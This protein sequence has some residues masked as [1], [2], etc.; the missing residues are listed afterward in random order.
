MLPIEYGAWLLLPYV[1]IR[2]VG[3]ANMEIGNTALISVR[4]L[5]KSF[6]ATKVLRGVN[7]TVRPGESHALLGGNGA[8]KSTMI[9]IITGGVRKDEGDVILASL[10]A[11]VPEFEQDPTQPRI[12]RTEP[13]VGYRMAEQE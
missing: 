3:V 7:F 2:V 8:G 1:I 9:R 13:S 6:G 10:R 12:V 5:K 4:N 11:S